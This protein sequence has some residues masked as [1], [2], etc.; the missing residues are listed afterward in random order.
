M[1]PDDTEAPADTP[2]EVGPSRSTTSTSASTAPWLPWA[3]HSRATA[4]AP[5]SSRR[6]R[7]SPPT[8]SGPDLALGP[9][10][11]HGYAERWSTGRSRRG[12]DGPR[13]HAHSTGTH[14]RNPNRATARSTTTTS[15]R[16]CARAPVAAGAVRRAPLPRLAE[17]R[18]D[19]VGARVQRT[20]RSR[21]PPSRTRRPRARALSLDLEEDAP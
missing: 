14:R 4:A 9:R 19:R 17:H 20:D 18:G 10:P 3:P 11:T 15:G 1:T 6:T 8:G 16:S 5:K 7:S 21:A 12:D 2:A 13:R